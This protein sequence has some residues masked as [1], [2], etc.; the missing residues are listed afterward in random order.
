MAYIALFDILGF[1]NAILDLNLDELKNIMGDEFSQ[2]LDVCV[3]YNPGSKGLSEFGTWEKYVEAGEQKSSYIRFSDTI[4]LYTDEDNDKFF[5]LLLSCSRL[6]AF[7]LLK[8]LP[9]R[10]AITKGEVFVDENNSLVIGE[11]LIRAYELEKIQQWSGAIIDPDRI[12]IPHRIYDEYWIS[13]EYSEN[14][15]FWGVVA[16]TKMLYKYPVPLKNGGRHKY[17]SLGWP[18]DLESMP[19]EH[20]VECFSNYHPLSDRSKAKVMGKDSE[21]KLENTRTYNSYKKWSNSFRFHRSLPY[22]FHVTCH[23]CDNG[24]IKYEKGCPGCGRV[25]RRGIDINAITK[26]IDANK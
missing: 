19:E 15:K 22:W 6:L 14:T 16:K 23:V 17:W 7:M 5:H 9:A 21:E 11:G 25:S 3:T 8:G 24:G 4:L 26:P 2:T 18:K 12:E 20:M 10:G 13:D 1:K